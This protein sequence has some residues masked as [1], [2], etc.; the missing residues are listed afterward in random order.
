MLHLNGV[1]SV[2][3]EMISDIK[4]GHIKSACGVYSVQLTYISCLLLTVQEFIS[5]EQL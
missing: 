3:F 2:H 5:V 1:E 4:R